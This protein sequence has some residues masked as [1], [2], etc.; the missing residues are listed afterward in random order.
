ML[1]HFS[2]LQPNISSAKV[3]YFLEEMLI[4]TCSSLT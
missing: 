2:L 4:H 3:P 1:D